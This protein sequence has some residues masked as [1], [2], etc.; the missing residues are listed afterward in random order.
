MISDRVA[1][2]FGVEEHDLYVHRAHSGLPEVEF[3][4]PVGI[5]V[6]EYVA[7]L[8]EAQQVFVL[9]RVMANIARRVH[10]VDK[11]PPHAVET[12]MACAARNVD[13]S[14]GAGLA[15]EE[16]LSSFAKRVYKSVS[17]RGRGRMEEAASMFLGAKRPEIGEWVRRVRLTAARA[18]LVLADDL[19]GPIDL[20]RRTESDLAGLQ[21]EPLANGIRL[22]QD[23][24]RFW[25]SEQ[26]LSLRRRLGLL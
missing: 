19:P 17:W 22:V 24:M 2:A 23:L 25:L 1:S 12:L 8:S 14:F 15:D 18:A 13:P 16:Y 9:A 5:L 10:V 11:L 26:A 20:V 4:D 6:P 7:N 21:G 3:T